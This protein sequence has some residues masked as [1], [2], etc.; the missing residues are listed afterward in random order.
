MSHPRRLDLQWRSL[1]QGLYLLLAV[2]VAVDAELQ[3][4]AV[5]VILL[6]E[7]ANLL[8]VDN[9]HT[10]HPLQHTD[11]NL[12][13]DLPQR[14]QHLQFLCLRLNL[15]LHLL[16][17]LLLRLLRSVQL[18]QHLFTP[19]HLLCLRSVLLHQFQQR[20]LLLHL[21]QGHFLCQ[22]AER[23]KV[24]Q[25][26][27][28]RFRVLLLVHMHRGLF[29]P[30][31]S[32]LCLFRPHTKALRNC[33]VLLLLELLSPLLHRRLFPQYPKRRPTSMA[34]PRL[35]LRPRPILCR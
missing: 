3:L 19:M 25:H 27:H 28:R 5:V 2:A 6:Q 34:C 10:M 30:L 33:Q 4:R 7:L 26:L 21:W 18:L 17:R 12:L 16:K 13:L 11:K 31:R 9:L 23:V 15:Y 20:A 8:V 32:V 22:L 24:F 29:L 35:C 14:A 1:V